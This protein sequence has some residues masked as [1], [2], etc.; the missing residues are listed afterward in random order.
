MKILLLGSKEV[1]EV[2]KSHPALKNKKPIAAGMF[3]GVFEGN[4][5][6]TVLKLTICPSSYALLTDQRLLGT[7][8][9]PQLIKDHGVVGQF[10]TGTN[11][12]ETKLT[13]AIIKDVPMYLVE[14]ERLQKVPIGTT[15][16]VIT[17][18][19]KAIKRAMLATL[20]SES[21]TVN[22]SNAL[23]ELCQ[24]SKHIGGIQSYKDYAESLVS[25]MESHP[26]A[27]Y[28]T[29]VANFMQRE[30]GTLVFSD[31]VGSIDIYKT[32]GVF[33]KLSDSDVDWT[34]VQQE[35]RKKFS[36]L[37]NLNVA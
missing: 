14:I 34:K 16:Q 17:H 12:K 9:T 27:F 20:E 35:H 23:L 24:S 13:K 21:H 10:K 31:P 19:S 2:R 1:R 33:S 8:H 22:Q 29:H 36:H 11:I 37:K 3:S 28:D 6:N 4:S 15:K 26:D 25:F 5:P 30:D 7:L 18:I 32:Q